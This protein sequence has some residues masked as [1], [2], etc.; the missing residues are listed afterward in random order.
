MKLGIIIFAQVQKW[1][2]LQKSFY[3]SQ[4]QPVVF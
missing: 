4:Q 1:Q 2:F 3:F